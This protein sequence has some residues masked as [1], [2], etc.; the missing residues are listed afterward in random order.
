LA[1]GRPFILEL[2]TFCA[3]CEI[4][5][6]PQMSEPKRPKWLP[7]TGPGNLN[8][9]PEKWGMTLKQWSAFIMACKLC[10]EKWAELEAMTDRK[11]EGDVNLYQV[12]D[13]FVKPWTRNL[14]NSI[15]LL[16]NGDNPLIAGV[17]ISHAWGEDIVESMIGILGRA[18]V[19]GI[20]LGTAIWFCTFAQYQPG[21]MEGD[22]GPGVASQLAL[23][24]FK[25]VIESKPRFGMLVI[26]TSAA[27]LYG[28]LWCVYE[29]HA[30]QDSGVV[31]SAAVSMKY[32]VHCFERAMRGESD[33]DICACQVEAATCWSPD[34]EKMI[35]AKIEARI[36][37][38]E[39]NKKIFDFRHASVNRMISAFKGL[40]PWIQPMCMK[41]KIMIPEFLHTILVPTVRAAGIFVGLH[42]L[43]TTAA[44]SED[45]E[46]FQA[47]MTM[48]R[49]GPL[50][51]L[52]NRDPDG[53][54]MG[55]PP[56]FDPRKKVPDEVISKLEHDDDLLREYL[57]NLTKF[58]HP[59]GWIEL[60]AGGNALANI[61][62]EF[63]EQF[64]ETGDNMEQ[65]KAMFERWDAD[66]NGTI[67]KDELKQVFRALSSDM[68]DNDI[69]TMLLAADQ[70][71]DGVVDYKEFIDWLS[72][73]TSRLA[74]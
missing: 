64:G 62:R 48:L 46:Y 7:R 6:A 38:E 37:Y 12:C 49:D 23:D 70:N 28:R 33:V 20:S 35:K 29:V 73:K 59:I 42:C 2:L 14:G 47:V 56:G 32:F 72:G 8:V 69:E 53:E 55:L 66:G 43:W 3:A 31:T 65:V 24:P 26:H 9:S 71:A 44:E 60:G 22:C 39:L 5:F 50:S 4:R 1:H 54:E 34:D 67:S 13:H 58:Q 17:M 74:V 11:R 19:S 57:A 36:G 40:L 10:Q 30:S 15:A 68:S 25:K 52:R 51:L 45:E 18:S 27:E 16:L 21:D 41:H 61:S 63:E